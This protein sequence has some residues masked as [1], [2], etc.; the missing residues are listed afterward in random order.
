MHFILLFKAQDV[1]DS[2][3]AEAIYTLIVIADDADILVPRREKCS[4]HILRVVRILI[5]IDHYVFEAVLIVFA[6]LLVRLEELHHVDYQI[7]KVHGVRRLEE[8]LIFLID[9]AYLLQ[10]YISLTR[11]NEL[12][13]V[14][15]SSLARL[16]SASTDLTGIIFSSY[17]RRFMHSLAARL[18]SSES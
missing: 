8:L 17:P 13:G 16:I 3:A 6:G 10:A 12:G 11:R 9:L 14:I 15:S 18:E 2:C 7:V 4:E 5:L 1:F